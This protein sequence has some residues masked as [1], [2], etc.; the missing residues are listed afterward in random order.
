MSRGALWAQWLRLSKR[1]TFVGE[2][3][4]GTYGSKDGITLPA[5]VVFYFTVG[6]ALWPDGRKYHGVGVVPD[7]VIKPTLAGLRENRDG[8]FDG[9]V[10]TLRKILRTPSRPQHAR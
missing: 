8:M 2:P 3:T 1:A 4:S 9:A 5:G 10:R 7:V 6:R